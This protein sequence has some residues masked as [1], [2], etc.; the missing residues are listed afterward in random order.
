MM[1][2]PR[3]SMTRMVTKG[4]TSREG[5]TQ[6]MCTIKKCIHMYIYIYIFK[7]TNIRNKKIINTKKNAKT[8][9]V[10]IYI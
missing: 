2:N 6:V 1:T 3:T 8:K 5:G 9:N 7:I 4:M 10:Y